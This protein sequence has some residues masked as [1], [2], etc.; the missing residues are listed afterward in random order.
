M[1][2]H[3]PS[4]IEMFCYSSQTGPI[5]RRHHR[6]QKEVGEGLMATWGK[7][8]KVKLSQSHWDCAEIARNGKEWAGRK[9]YVQADLY[10]STVT[11]MRKKRQG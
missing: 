4:L 10:Q 8:V 11:V 9:K 2:L 3:G 7:R 1:C 5:F 6:K